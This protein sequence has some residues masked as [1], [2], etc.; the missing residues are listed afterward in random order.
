M[1]STDILFGAGQNSAVSLQRNSTVVERL[2]KRWG[3]PK[4]AQFENSG[5]PVEINQLCGIANGCSALAGTRMRSEPVYRGHAFECN[6]D[7]A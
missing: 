2:S 4:A 7:G 6:W 1:S 5:P 3:S